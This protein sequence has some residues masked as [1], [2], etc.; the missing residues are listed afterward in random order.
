MRTT[1]GLRK[2]WREMRG[3]PKEKSI[4]GFVDYQAIAK[5]QKEII[6]RMDREAE[7]LRCELSSSQASLARAGK[8]LAEWRPVGWVD[9]ACR[10]CLPHGEIVRDGF[11]C[12][13][14]TALAA[15]KAPKKLKAVEDRRETF[16]EREGLPAPKSQE[17]P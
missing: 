12:A 16:E 4:G 9:H 14:H 17:K 7:R 8:L 6:D 5:E 15:I 1:D 3:A 2:Y 10:Q 11:V 13:Y